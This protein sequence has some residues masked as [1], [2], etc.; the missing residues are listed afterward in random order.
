MLARNNF[1]NLPVHDRMN[2]CIH[3][4]GVPRA[5][6]KVGVAIPEKRITDI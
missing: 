1:C 5:R 3:V 4:D 6:K 2:E